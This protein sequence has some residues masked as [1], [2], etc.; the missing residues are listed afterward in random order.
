MARGNPNRATGLSASESG[1]SRSVY[2]NLEKMASSISPDSKISRAAASYAALV[3]T[4][5]KAD[6]EK[7]AIDS[8]DVAQR[9]LRKVFG[10]ATPAEQKDILDVLEGMVSAV[11][12]YQTEIDKEVKASRVSEAQVAAYR[13][14]PRD[15][16]KQVLAA[17]EKSDYDSGYPAGGSAR[18]AEIGASAAGKGKAATFAVADKAAETYG[19]PAKQQVVGF[20][21]SVDQYPIVKQLGSKVGEE[22]AKT[23]RQAEGKAEKVGAART[24]TAYLVV[25]GLRKDKYDDNSAEVVVVTATNQGNGQFTHSIRKERFDF[26]VPSRNYLD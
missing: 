1:V 24:G 2:S 22:I 15:V 13:G 19:G 3:A 21:K 11:R 4:A 25:P 23:I 7:R 5:L 20:I 14:L 10:S 9:D 6:D 17:A 18:S 16:R 8:A 26:S 12:N